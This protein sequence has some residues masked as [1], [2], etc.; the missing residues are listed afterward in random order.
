MLL[1]CFQAGGGGGG[2]VVRTAT[3]KDR[4]KGVKDDS[5]FNAHAPDTSSVCFSHDA[6]ISSLLTG[7]F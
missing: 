5:S 7:G 1:A 6:S 2:G 4:L 3:L